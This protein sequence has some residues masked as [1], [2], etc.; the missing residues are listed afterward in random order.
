MK[1]DRA[2]AFAVVAAEPRGLAG[3]ELPAEDVE[4]ATDLVR[5]FAR[6]RLRRIAEA[7]LRRAEQLAAMFGLRGAA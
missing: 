2:R 1:Y 3:D 6:D 4:R 7:E 5:R